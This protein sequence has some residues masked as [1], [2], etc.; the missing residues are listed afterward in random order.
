VGALELSATELGIEGF[1]AKNGHYRQWYKI[2]PVKTVDCKI[3]HATKSF[4]PTHFGDLEAVLVAVRDGEKW[5]TIASVGNGFSEEFR[6][7]VKRKSLVGR[8]CEI[9]YSGLA[10]NGK[11][12]FPRFERFRDDKPA[13]DCTICQLDGLQA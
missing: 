5:I 1:V 13:K 9:S 10:A 11:L 8:V 3:I 12:L 4:A 6:Q 7:T 2:K